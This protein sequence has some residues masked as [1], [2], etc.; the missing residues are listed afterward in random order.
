MA[1]LTEEGY[2]IKRLRDVLED[3]RAKAQ[4][5]FADL[6][7]DGDVVNTDTNSVL[8]RMIG[9]IAPSVADAWEASQS[10]YD[11][12]NINAATDVAL[13][14]LCALGGV[15]RQPAS[16]TITSVFLKG[17]YLTSIP[18][19]TK[20]QSVN[21]SRYHSV[22]SSTSLDGMSSYEITVNVLTVANSTDYTITYLKVPDSLSEGTLSATITSDGS[23]TENE[24]LT[25]LASEINTNHNTVLSASVSGSDLIVQSVDEF[26]KITFGVSSNL[27]VAQVEKLVTVVCDDAGPIEQ[28]ANTITK[29]PVPI[30]GWDSVRNP[31]SGITGRDVE[32]DSELRSRYKIAKFGDGDN[33]IESLYSALYALDGVESV[34]IIENDTDTTLT[35]PDPPVPPHSFMTI[36]QG[37]ASEEIARAIWNNKPAGI[38]AYG[39]NTVTVYDSQ[40]IGHGVSYST[41][42]PVDIYIDVNITTQPDFAPDGA[43][44]IKAA[45]IEHFNSLLIGD[46]VIYSRLYTPI[47]SISGFYVDSLDVDTSPSPSGTSNITIAYDERAVI[48]EANINVIV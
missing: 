27:S 37:G 13:D 45:I 35:L 17:D 43:D 39:A 14:N 36:V 15:I 42:T 2:T 6:V 4:E 29:I 40:E 48:T 44:Q 9:V 11:A 23:A 46:D 28:P 12:F 41:P 16:S 34:V 32:T 30:V 20:V 22:N 7:E 47:N 33:L 31:T 1:G 25:A 18:S 8:G 19:G 38:L 24:I 5:I 26:A 21:N 10:V 3:L